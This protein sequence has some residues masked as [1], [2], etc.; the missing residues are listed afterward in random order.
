[1]TETHPKLK[2]EPEP[3]QPN[4]I[5]EASQSAPISPNEKPY[6][7][8]Q[9]FEIMMELQDGL[10]IATIKT[11]QIREQDMN[12]HTMP[13]L[14]FR[15]LSEN[16]HD[17]GM[18]ESLPFCAMIDNRIEMVSGHH[19]KRAASAAGLEDI[20]ILLDTSGLTRDQ[21][22]A[23]QLAHNSINGID[24]IQI[25]KQIYELINDAE[26]KIESFIDPK[27]L[28]IE[29]PDHVPITDIMASNMDSMTLMFVF[30]K[31]Q[32]ANFEDVITEISLDAISKKIDEVDVIEMEYFEKFKRA[33][34][35]VKDIDDIRA[36]GM[37]ISKMCDIVL[38]H[39]RPLREEREAALI[40]ETMDSL[41]EGS[42]PTPDPT[43]DPIPE[44]EILY[45]N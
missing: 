28:E 21:I 32:Q 24:D 5:P 41:L 12:A 6:D 11:D 33:L 40:P 37:V 9:E 29:F 8:K 14:M 1:M 17:R 25:V 31:H 36:I 27:E 38:E 34:T 16:I 22:R 2:P 45:D 18:L 15:Q 35:D 26:A 39:Y 44:G 20:I 42:D 10:C 13:A 30:L 23:K 4:P 43:S 3:K 7:G 19:R